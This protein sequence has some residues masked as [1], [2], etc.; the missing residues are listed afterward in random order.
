MFAVHRQGIHTPLT[1]REVDGMRYYS[2]LQSAWVEIEDDARS[3]AE[4]TVRPPASLPLTLDHS[5]PPAL[6]EAAAALAPTVH[7]TLRETEDESWDCLWLAR[8][9]RLVQEYQPGG[10]RVVLTVHTLGGCVERLEWRAVAH[11]NLRMGL[12]RV[13]ARKGQA[14]VALPLARLAGFPWL[15][16]RPGET[17]LAG[18]KN[19]KKFVCG[20]SLELVREAVTRLKGKAKGTR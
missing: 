7:F 18:E 17:V 3:V 12:G 4:H 11:R 6:A 8:L 9:R 15:G 13:L 16:V 5:Q 10:N 1:N 19:W 20:T 2:P 14:E